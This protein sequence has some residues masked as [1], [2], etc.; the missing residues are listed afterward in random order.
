MQNKNPFDNNKKIDKSYILK[1]CNIVD[2]KNLKIRNGDIFL[3][4][5]LIERIGNNLS[6]TV[7]SQTKVID[8]SDL[9]V[10]PGLIDMRVSITE[11]GHEHKETIKSASKS[12]A[13]GGITSII[14]MPNT[15]PPIDQPAIIHSIQRRAREVALS[16]VFCTGC[17]TRNFKGDEICELHLMQESGAVGF[18][19]GFKTIANTRVMRRALNYAKS[20]DGLIIQHAEDPFLGSNCVVNESEIS[21]RMG[22]KGVPSFAEAMIVQR[23]LW[24]VE[25]TKCRYHV[26]HISAKETVEI[27]RQAKKKGLPVTCDT[28]PPYFTL[29]E[30]S[31]EN[32]RTFSKLSPPLRNE[33]DRKSIVEGICDG[34]IDAISSDHT[35]QDQDAKRLPFNQAEFGGIGL[36]TLLPLTLSLVN[37]KKIDLIK[38]MSLITINPAK[39]L[40]LDVG[41]IEKKREADLCIFSTSKPWKVNPEKFHGKS[42]N[43][44]FD[45]MLVE[46]KNLMTFVRGRLVYEL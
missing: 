17:I 27:I 13:S 43:S 12:A 24:M 5:K 2:T 35:P 4:N 21:T 34:T 1:N 31:L 44:P 38:A 14:C 37:N 3:K 23:D 16:K 41:K 29:N 15:S 36:E 22:L 10:S 28:S 18:T 42:K 19:D 46:G 33:E 40:K 32:Y 8:C 45:G 39:I 11:P 30:L 26:G 20:F 25:E 9:Y 6:D 7:D